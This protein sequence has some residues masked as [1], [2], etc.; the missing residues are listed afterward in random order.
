MGA[1]AGLRAPEDPR[2][3]ALAGARPFLV[4]LVLLAI[5]PR[6][7]DAPTIQGSDAAPGVSV[8]A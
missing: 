8:D 3:D 4:G 7:G 1:G 2:E 5:P 6:Y